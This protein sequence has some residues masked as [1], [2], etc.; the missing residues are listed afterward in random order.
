MDQVPNVSNKRLLFS[1][2][3]DKS[4]TIDLSPRSLSIMGEW[5]RK[6]IK[7]QGRR[8]QMW[9]REDV[10]KV[11]KFRGNT[12]TGDFVWKKEAID[13]QQRAA[14]GQTRG[15]QLHGKDARI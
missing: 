3:T 10:L 11:D 7:T 5:E 14:R 13:R 8:A 4:Q 15:G 9:K 1:D 6:I 2:C 12:G